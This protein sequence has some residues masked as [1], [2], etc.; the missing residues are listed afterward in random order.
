MIDLNEL[1]WK[2]YVIKKVINT[3][4]LPDKIANSWEI[5]RKER[6]NPFQARSTTILRMDE[7]SSKQLMNRTMI[8]L[9][10]QES[11]QIEQSFKQS[12]SLFILTD[13]EGYILWRK[14]NARAMDHANR[15]GFLEGSRW[16]ELDVG[17]NAISLTL[18]NKESQM[19]S[20]FEHYA[21]AS[22][23][24]SCYACPIFDE[25][26]LVG[27]L[28]MST[29][30][31]DS[32]EQQALVQLIVE[33]VNNGLLRRRLEHNQALMTYIV[34]NYKQS[35]LCNEKFEIVYLPD[36]LVQKEQLTIGADI[37]AFTQ[38][39]TGL[40]NKEKIY[41]EQALIG[42]KY[43]FYEKATHKD[44]YYPGVPSCN[45]SYQTFLEQTFQA[46]DSN[47]PVHI[48]G[49]SGSGKEVIAE[50]IHYNS[51]Y[52]DGPL[53]SVNCGSLSENLLE[54][55]LFGYAAGAFTGAS[56][57]GYI[58]KVRQAQGGTLF[59][60]EID[61]MSLKMQAALLRAL[62]EKQVTPIGSNNSY[63]V[64]F[65]LV[66]ATNQDLKQAVADSRFREDLYYRLYV[67]PLQIP[68]LRQR[69]E[70]LLPLIERFCDQQNWA[71]TW[72]TKLYHVASQYPWY[73]NIREFNNF[74][75]R[76]YVFYPQQEP[77]EQ[78]LRD[79]IELTA[80]QPQHE[81]EPDPSANDEA[82][83]ILKALE[84]HNYHKANT[85]VALN[86]SRTTLYRKIKQYNL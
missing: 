42:Y 47:V 61:S 13:P 53:V 79:L 76:L 78:A 29:Y 33:R 70:D 26:T 7:L 83:N 86:I 41:H 5:C 12:E 56:K 17:T 82:A 48:K 77:S 25:D 43:T 10:K 18:K 8:D 34:G 30:K 44:K 37:Q 80:L 66:T 54:S 63:S 38:Q 46:A 67:C 55:E 65:R 40:F 21:V 27:V 20:R 32:V 6:L 84:Q 75:Q 14:G 24:W 59:L 73:G 49:E 31:Q 62:E 1:L 16:N 60:D 15:I 3:N 58:G 9:V 28:D 45:K 69:T 68:P 71:I 19:V 52:K 50:T 39:F 22:H 4:E 11:H 2:E 64:D 72:Q 51:P 57:D 81:P 35:I 85:A 36:E 23:D 74:L